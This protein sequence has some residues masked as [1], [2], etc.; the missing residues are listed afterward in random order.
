[1]DNLHRNARQAMEAFAHRHF[2]TVTVNTGVD[3]K[4]VERI[5]PCTPLQ[6]GIIYKFLS[7]TL[8][9]YCNSFI[10]DL[11]S[12]VNLDKLQNAWRQAQREV[13]MLRARFSPSCD[14]YAQVI[15]KTDNFPWYHLHAKSTEEMEDRRRQRFERWVSKLE[16]L[17]AQLWEVGVVQSP[18]KTVMYLNIFHALYDGNSLALLLELVAQCYFGQ[19]A[20]VRR[21]P[22]FLDVLHLGPLCKHSSE[23]GFWTEHLTDCHNRSLVISN[24]EE[25][26]VIIEKAQINTRYLDSLK[27]A[28]GVTEQAILHASWLLTLH[29]HYAFVPPLGIITSGRTIDAEDIAGVIGPLFNTIPSNIQFHNLETWSQVARRCHEFHVSTIPFQNTALRDIMKWLGKSSGERLFDSLFVFQ[30]ES[31][32]SE[33]LAKLLWHPLGSEA[34]HDYP[35]ALEILRRD[36]EDL[37]LTLAAKGDVLSAS[38]A[39]TLLASLKRVVSDF[40]SDPERRLVQVHGLANFELA[41]TDGISTRSDASVKSTDSGC[42]HSFKWT[43]EARTLRDVIAS[44]AEVEPDTIAEH[45][46]IFE[47]GLDSIDAIKLS[48]RLSKYGIKLPV[49]L[50][51]RQR[52]I[53]SMIRQLAV[54]E[55]PEKNGSCPLLDQMERDLAGFL[56]REKLLPSDHCRILPATPIQE[57]M[58]AEMSASRY[59]RY[60]N[61]EILQIE[62]HVDMGRL[63]KAWEA[64]IRAH[65]I[66]RTSFIEVWDPYIPVAFAQ[67]VHNEETVDFQMVEL[68]GKPVDSIIEM[69][70]ERA[71][72][73][74]AGQPLLTLTAAIEGDSRYLVLSIAHALYDGWSINLLHEDIARSYSGNDCTRPPPDAL[75]EQIIASSGERACS[76]WKATLSNCT[77]LAFPTE[78]GAEARSMVVHRVDKSLPVCTDKADAFCR[79]HGVTMQTLL[80]SCWSL[81]LAS[82]VKKLDVVFGLVLSGRNMSESENV[83]FPTMNTVAMRVILHGTRLE[84]VKYVQEILLEISEH[85]HFPLRR[86][87]ANAAPRQLFDTLFIYQKTPMKESGGGTVLYKS[88][89]STSE[90]EYPVCAEVEAAGPELIGRV[91][92]LESVLGEKSTSALLDHMAHVLSSIIDDSTRHTVEFTPEDTAICGSVIVED[93]ARQG[94][95]TGHLPGGSSQEHWNPLEKTIRNVLAIVSGVPEHSIDKQS[96]L[97]QLGLDSI[98]AIKATALLK[99]QSVRL[100][101]SDMLKA[102]T[103]ERMAKAVNTNCVDLTSPE[104]DNALLESLS[105]IDV[106]S[107]LQQ[108]KIE[109]CQTLRIMPAT[110][111]QTYFLSMHILNPDVFYPEF[112]YLVSPCL[113]QEILQDAWTHLTIRAPMLRTAFMATGSWNQVPYIQ[114]VLENTTDSVVWHEAIDSLLGKKTAQELGTVPVTLHACQSPEGT[115]LVLHIHHA[116]YDAVSLPSMIDQLAKFCGQTASESE[117][118]DDH[119]KVVAYQHVHSTVDVRRQFWQGYLGQFSTIESKDDSTDRFGAIQQYYRPGLVSNMSGV[120]EAA[121]RQSLSVQSMFLAVFARVY[122]RILIAVGTSHQ[123][124]RRHLVVGLYLANRSDNAGNLG[125]LMVPTVNIVPLRLDDKLSG[126]HSSLPTAALR[127]QN[128][129]NRISMVENASVSLLEIAEWTGV[130][131]NTCVNFLRLP[132]SDAPISTINHQVAIK[133]VQRG[134]LMEFKEPRLN[135]IFGALT[136]G[137][138]ANAPSSVHKSGPCVSPAALEDVFMVCQH[139]LRNITSISTG[140]TLTQI[141]AAHVGC[142][143][144]NS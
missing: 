84:F 79:R 30:K 8:P 68:N 28:L 56:E 110:A 77:P 39:Q 7:T 33:S 66:L 140:Q 75:L 41:Q 113:E 35:L 15:L 14:G 96:N 99:R 74:L 131:I 134:D 104:V 101:V 132:E 97:F 38:A 65:P 49:S 64:V 87:K 12:T 23:K 111:G 144:R 24:H 112:Y 42:E 123:D 135:P 36:S 22:D 118:L 71:Y 53:K 61:H 122:A 83:M 5:A 85:Q 17:S 48:S 57:A 26:R 44:F 94:A 29:Q 107:V 25:S 86:V 6:E 109:R 114:A 91:A 141:R 119:S 136:S 128:D 11:D 1:M 67:V 105:D 138:A 9:L 103:I 72:D 50:I 40:A 47:V 106:D 55:Q 21:P 62:P 93:G 90:I 92:C 4:D 63:Q 34:L 81:V 82:Y 98:S 3:E 37:A 69:Q 58:I 133:P 45:T 78:A 124:L 59:Q 117:Q 31:A 73:K 139:N 142:R 51:M 2:H 16:G 10:F 126:D 127:I 43:P 143:G 60:Y 20:T 108:H 100:T 70:R 18:T 46:S 116:L 125:E 89:G 13:Q 120:E 137:H 130:R 95:G 76:F 115:A 129:I 88:V 19:R 54:T 32:K 102:G 27:K 52:T 121:R 80:V